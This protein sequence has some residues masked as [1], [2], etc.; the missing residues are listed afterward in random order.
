MSDPD[1]ITR[2]LRALL[3]HTVERLET[4]GV[5][6]EAI[7]TLLPARRIALIRRP[8]V[9]EPVARAWRL[10]VL[11][12]GRDARLFGTGRITRAVEPKHATVYLNEESRQRRELRQAAARGDFMPGDVVN[13]DVVE[14]PLDAEGLRAASGPLTLHGDT[15][16]VR[17]YEGQGDDALSSL[18]SYLAERLAILLDD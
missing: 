9:M 14:I 7:A 11:L 3:A 2:D 10:G 13:F 1:P 8:A 17:W 18:E 6:D 16:M 4:M 12:L 15:V 5:G